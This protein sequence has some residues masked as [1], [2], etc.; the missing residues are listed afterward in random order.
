MTETIEREYEELADYFVENTPPIIKSIIDEW[1]GRAHLNGILKYGFRIRVIID[2]NIILSEVNAYLKYGESFFLRLA[3]HSIFEPI[4]PAYLVEELERKA[5]SLNGVKKGEYTEE[6]VKNAIYTHFLP[7]IKLLPEERYISLVEGNQK[8]TELRERDEK[9]IPYLVVYLGE[10]AHGILTRDKDLIELN[11]TMTFEKV[12]KLKKV[13]YKIEKG[14]LSMVLLFDMLPMAMM[15]LGKLIF[16]AI[17]AVLKA[18]YDFA[19]IVWTGIKSLAKGAFDAFSSLH[20]I[21]QLGLLILGGYLAINNADKIGKFV[22]KT[23][24]FTVE[25]AKM[26]IEFLKSVAELVK[27]LVIISAKVASAMLNCIFETIELYEELETRIELSE[28]PP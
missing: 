12:G 28:A 10:P 3:Q 1:A 11:G 8:V 18:L 16:Y 6:E 15:A 9:D 13:L 2:A 14:N 25:T 17:F 7:K 26:I 24:E 4:A 5:A 22:E 19:V 20:P 21:L 23:I 27:E